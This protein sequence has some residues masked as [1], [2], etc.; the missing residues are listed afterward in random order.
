[1][2]Q[3]FRE[4][5]PHSL[6]MNTPIFIVGIR[7]ICESLGRAQGGKNLVLMGK[8]AAEDIDDRALDLKVFEFNGRDAVLLGEKGLGCDS[9]AAL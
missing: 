4:V 2:D 9:H 3:I 8:L 7:R 6:L 1:M 5:P